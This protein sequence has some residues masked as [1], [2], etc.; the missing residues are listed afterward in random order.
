MRGN[1]IFL[2]QPGFH[3]GSLANDVSTKLALKD[4]TA[5]LPR[6]AL[7]HLLLCILGPGSS[8]T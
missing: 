4:L 5:S 7:R 3:K 1:I 6:P 2:W 8:E